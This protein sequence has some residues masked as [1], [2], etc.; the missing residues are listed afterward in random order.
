MAVA[1]SSLLTVALGTAL[2][3]AVRAVRSRQH[4][5][6]IECGPHEF[7]RGSD[8]IAAGDVHS[9]SLSP[10]SMRSMAAP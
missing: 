8:A 10:S 1:L 3:V 7:A 5:W 2:S 6:I 9:S 4:V